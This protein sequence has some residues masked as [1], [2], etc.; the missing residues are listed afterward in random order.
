MGVLKWKLEIPKKPNLDFMFTF[1]SI[2]LKLQ[3]AL[4]YP[5]FC[6]FS[7]KGDTKKQKWVQNMVL[8]LTEF[9]A[10]YF[11]Q[12][13]CTDIGLEKYQWSHL[14]Q[15]HYFLVNPAKQY[16]QIMTEMEWNVPGNTHQTHD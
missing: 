9:S 5:T 8:L 12:Y 4:I 2:Y 6:F 14:K 16:I 3:I 7:S 1:T 13:V 15:K 11:L 10:A